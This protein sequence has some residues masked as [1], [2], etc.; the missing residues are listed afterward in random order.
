M[1]AHDTL[2]TET[3]DNTFSISELNSI[4][5]VCIPKH[6]IPS[7]LS[8]DEKEDEEEKGNVAMMD[9][10]VHHQIFANGA[11]IEAKRYRAFCT[12]FGACSTASEC[13]L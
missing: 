4:I 8:Q 5:L 10:L 1:S 9:K 3:T 6:V 11:R 2:S 7:T 13:I 12:N